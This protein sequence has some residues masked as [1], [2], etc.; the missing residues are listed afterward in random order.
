MFVFARRSLVPEALLRA[1]A[2]PVGSSALLLEGDW[3]FEGAAGLL[4]LDTTID[5]ER[6]AGLDLEA[7]RLATQLAAAAARSATSDSAVDQPNF[8]DINAL[9]L[10]YEA[11]RWLRV[12]AFWREYASHGEANCEASDVEL[13]M[14]PGRDD[15]YIALWRAMSRTF[16]FT[17]RIHFVLREEETT[18]RFKTPRNSWWR[19]TLGRCFANHV[20]DRD[21]LSLA[22]AAHRPRLLFVGNPRILDPV[23]DAALDR[24]AHVAWLY[25]RFAVGAWRKRRGEGIAWLTCDG[26]A[27]GGDDFSASLLRESVSYRGVVLD[28]VAEAW[29]RRWRRR[30]GESQTRQWRRVAEHLDSLRPSRIVLDEDATPLARIVVAQAARL[31]IPTIVIQHGV[32]CVRFGFAPLAADVFCAWD[33]GTRRQLRAWGVAE[34]RIIVTGPTRD[35]LGMRRAIR[36]RRSSELSC[37]SDDRPQ[38]VVLLATMPPRDDRPDAIEF[39]L[40]TR[41]YAAMLHAACAAV[42]ELPNAELIVKLHPRAV[43]DSLAAR[44]L[45]QFPHL[46]HQVVTKVPLADALATADCVLSCVSSAGIDAAVA[47]LPVVQLLPQGSGSILPAEWYGLLGSART[48]DELRPLLRQ[49]LRS[50]SQADVSTSDDTLDVSAER[51][52]DAVYAA[53]S[54]T[55][56]DDSSSISACRRDLHAMEEA[57]HG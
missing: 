30:L 2:M 48:L 31:G 51:I 29:Y 10:R 17:L 21:R 44:T 1:G 16:G 46:R 49:A 19:R 15:E 5:A 50:R 41:T 40:T 27:E 56:D 32:C 13:Y 9:R 52:V 25:D 23:C 47:G 55:R 18:D 36:T 54:P 4:S 39:H 33:E 45:T 57:T 42:S 35:Q 43:T 37:A 28:D 7:Q 53:S 24:G 12:I 22:A 20:V 6:F 34:D 14:S 11:V 8:A 38:R 3:G 26:D